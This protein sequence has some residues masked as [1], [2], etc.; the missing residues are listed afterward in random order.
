MFS[1]TGLGIVVV[2]VVVVDV[3]EVEVDVE[4]VVEEDSVG[5]VSD[6]TAIIVGVVSE[7]FK[8]ADDSEKTK[9]LVASATTVGASGV[10][11]A[12]FAGT[13]TVVTSAR[14]S[15]LIYLLKGAHFKHSL[16]KQTFRSF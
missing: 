16:S 9:G 2:V 15:P 14:V 4:V 10:V 6:E 11:T 3:V 7:V 1:F 12:A 8:V 13:A 5:V